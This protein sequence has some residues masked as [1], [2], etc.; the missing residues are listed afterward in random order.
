MAEFEDY[1]TYRKTIA[2]DID[3]RINL[4]EAALAIAGANR[5]HLLAE[6]D[7]WFDYPVPEGNMPR[8]DVLAH[9][10]ALPQNPPLIL[11]LAHWGDATTQM[12]GLKQR[13][14]LRQVLTQP[15][16]PFDAI[17]FS[18]GGNDV[19]G[20]TFTLWL[21]QASSPAANPAQAVNDDAL[22][23][24]LGVVRAA[25]RDLMSLRD[26]LAP[27]VPIFT[28]GY[29]FAWPTNIG[30]CAIVG[31]W[32]A[33]SLRARGWM[34]DDSQAQVARGAVIVEA[35]LTRFNAMLGQLARA[36][37]ANLV[38]VQTQK[39]LVPTTDWANELH[40]NRAGFAKIAAQFQTALATRFPGRI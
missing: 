16:R 38:V 12:L 20:D 5:L 26:E 10:N 30:V 11:S 37:G 34:V 21:K 27:G 36:P 6:G 40:P 22:E 17:L 15:T 18:G 32:L 2:D 19:V 24:V 28:H 7:S 8:T 31:P 9:L 1:E 4:H 3:L 14:K 25:Y 29:D 33:P 39:T 13:A 23:A 35:I